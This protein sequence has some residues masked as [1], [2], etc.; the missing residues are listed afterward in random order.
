[1]D[2]KELVKRIEENRQSVIDEWKVYKE[3][4]Y[5]IPL[6]EEYYDEGYM[7]ALKWV[8]KIIKED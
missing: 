6:E 8:M 4:E 7:N 1:M 5:E 2:M 3:E